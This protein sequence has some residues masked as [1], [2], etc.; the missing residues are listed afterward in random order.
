[1]TGKKSDDPLRPEDLEGSFRQEFLPPLDFST[2]VLP[3]FTQA[4][5]KLGL[6]ADQEKTE[7]E[8][9]LALARRLIDILDLLKDRTKGN[10]APE[11]EKFLGSCLQQLKAAYLEKAK[12]IAL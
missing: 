6:L 1:M 12:I 8:M 2:I 11:E 10:L 3:I 4:L 9:N 7:P 5:L